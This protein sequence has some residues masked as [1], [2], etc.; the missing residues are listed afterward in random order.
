VTQIELP[1]RRP[2]EATRARGA[3]IRRSDLRHNEVHRTAGVPLTC[4]VLAAAAMLLWE[5]DAVVVPSVPNRVVLRSVALTV[6]FLAAIAL[7]GARHG[8]SYGLDRFRL[9]PWYLLVS[10]MS[11]GLASLAWRT[12]KLGV[13]AVIDRSSV[14]RA[15]AILGVAMPLWAVGY[16]IGP[17]R[18]ALRVGRWL[19]AAATSEK[20]GGTY[21]SAVMWAVAGVSVAARLTQILLGKFGYLADPSRLVSGSSWYAQILEL[22]AGCGL[23]ALVIA[24]VELARSGGVRRW[25]AFV[26][27]LVT[28]IG[29]GLLSGMKGQFVVTLLGVCVSF[30]VTRGRIPLR[31]I[32]GGAAI[33][34]FVIVPYNAAY[35]H[36]VRSPDRLSLPASAAVS[37]AWGVLTDTVGGSDTADQKSGDTLSGSAS[38][39]T[40]RVRAVDS[41]AVV[42]Q[43]TPELVPYRHL[44]ELVTNP[45]LGLV[46]RALWPDKPLRA[47]GYTFNQEYYGTDAHMYTA[48]GILPQADL[49]RYGGL[50]VVLIGS[51]FLGAGYRFVDETLHPSRDLRLTA[52]YVSLFALLLNS[53]MSVADMLVSLPIKIAVMVLV[54]RFVYRGRASS[55]AVSTKISWWRRPGTGRLITTGGS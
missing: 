20:A 51:V 23:G 40:V 6:E 53:E 38:Y 46:P 49:Y 36:A 8:R 25:T 14:A 54:C 22:A 3:D 55:P 43:K 24:A 4:I 16:L 35:R 50:I 1:A 41:L 33:L 34:L 13:L 5:I 9:G 48:A 30:T 31:W 52:L 28:E 7:I 42:I 26:L 29:F 10:A 2:P 39:L 44:S 19:A 18:P 21:S 12:P 11:M 15:L 27:L 47:T 32:F 45:V 17:G 37:S